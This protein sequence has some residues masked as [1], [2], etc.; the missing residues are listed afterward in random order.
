M[1]EWPVA[2]ISTSCPHPAFDAAARGNYLG[3]G[4]KSY[5]VLGAALGGRHRRA[6]CDVLRWGMFDPIINVHRNCINYVQVT[7][8]RQRLFLVLLVHH[9]TQ[10]V[11]LT[12]K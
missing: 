3:N 8:D 6:V 4:M 10:S 9:G 5:Q 12:A 2:D 11:R 1:P 7:A